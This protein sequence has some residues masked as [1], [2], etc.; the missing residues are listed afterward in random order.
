MNATNASAAAPDLWMHHMRHGDFSAAWEISDAVLQAH[1]G[2]PCHQWPRHF[3]YVWNGAS[4]A[5][6]RVL[7][8]CYHG[9]GDT[10][11]FI[12]FAPWVKAIAREIIVWAQPELLPLL[13]TAAGIDRLLPLHDGTP[14][15]DYDVDIELMELP[16]AFRLT[17]ETLP[18]TVPYLHAEPAT[19]PLLERDVLHVGIAW[20]VSDWEHER[21]LPTALAAQLAVPGVRLH[22]LQRGPALAEWPAD[23]GVISGRDR[24][25]EAAAVM[26][27]LDLVI[28]VDSFPAH[29]A[30][31]LGV[32]VWTL[33]PQPAN[34]RWLLDRQDSP[35]YPTMRL[36][37]QE[38]AG[39]WEP[40]IEQ[41]RAE[42]RV[43]AARVI[44]ER[45]VNRRRA[46]DRRT[47][48]LSP[49]PGVAI[50]P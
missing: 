8:R 39:K 26:R 40:L 23:L 28:S 10:V 4:L 38:R 15:I 12:R 45:L 30:G 42:L 41:V 27:A 7:I 29:L 50:C 31:A 48:Q 13:S 19:L 16:H 43:H 2:V 25:E 37:R 24:I 22:V 32:P 36:F 3:Q 9:L 6:Q 18:A 1:A 35:W 21:S 11:Q 20:R 17:L 14:D 49:P 47:G 46:P 34:W 5:G 44:G 33:L